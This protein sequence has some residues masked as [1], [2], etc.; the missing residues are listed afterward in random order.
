MEFPMLCGVAC[1]SN[2][3]YS[4]CSGYSYF[5]CTMSVLYLFSLDGGSAV[6]ADFKPDL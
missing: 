1:V 4:D 3:L 5:E 6:I 2:L